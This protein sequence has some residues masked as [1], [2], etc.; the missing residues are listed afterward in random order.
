MPKSIFI[1]IF[2]W[3]I[4]N[5]TIFLGF[6]TIWGNYAIF[7]AFF[8]F[9]LVATTIF[10]KFPAPWAKRNFHSPMVKPGIRGYP[11]AAGYLDEIRK[12]G[13]KLINKSST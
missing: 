1:K 2:V 13:D 12:K 3:H 8:I 9:A 5:V 10:Q 7:V 11:R 4:P 6:L